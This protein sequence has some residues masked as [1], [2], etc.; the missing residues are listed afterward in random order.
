M[1][2]PATDWLASGGAY[3]VLIIQT[4]VAAIVGSV[5]GFRIGMQAKSEGEGCLLA[6]LNPLLALLGAGLGFFSTPY[7]SYLLTSLVGA[8]ILPAIATA[9]F[10]R[11]ITRRR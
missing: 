2:V 8:L 4:A 7:P 3:T 11:I 5:I 10:S 6:I 9:G 1:S